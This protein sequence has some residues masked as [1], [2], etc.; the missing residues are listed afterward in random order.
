ML[1]SS[2]VVYGDPL[3]HPQMED[4]W[5]NANPLGARRVCDEAKRYAET[6]TMAYHRHHKVD[7]RIAR[8]FNA[9]GPRMRIDAGRTVPNFIQ[10]ALLRRP[11]TVTAEGPRA[12]ACSML[13]T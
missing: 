5:G 6:I 3:V 10:Q 12:G 13:T 7:T 9:Y 2:S 4:W 8:I 1:A 11:L